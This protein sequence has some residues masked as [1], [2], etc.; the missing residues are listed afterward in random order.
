M[1]LKLAVRDVTGKL[2]AEGTAVKQLDITEVANGTYLL[3][4]SDMEGKLLR[5]DKVTKTTN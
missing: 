1:K 4:I 5:A 3:Y 2:V